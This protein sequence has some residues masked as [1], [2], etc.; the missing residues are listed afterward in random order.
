MPQRGTVTEACI[1]ASATSPVNPVF[2]K[3]QEIYHH[4]K[5]TRVFKDGKP[6][7][8]LPAT[9]KRR[10][11]GGALA[12]QCPDTEATCRYMVIRGCQGAGRML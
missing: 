7:A 4:I 5:C 9:P 2:V 12:S 11:P 6:R 1:Y 10:S 8:S 3:P